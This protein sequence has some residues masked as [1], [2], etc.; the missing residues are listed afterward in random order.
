MNIATSN[1]EEDLLN[2]N[3]EYASRNNKSILK[4]SNSMRNPSS[5]TSAYNK[6]PQSKSTD[7]ISDRV[8]GGSYG[9]QMTQSSSDNNANIL[10]SANASKKKQLEGYE[11]LV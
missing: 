10:V 2:N 1:D 3:D 8:N 5:T 11:I 7:S 6:I 9:S 4:H